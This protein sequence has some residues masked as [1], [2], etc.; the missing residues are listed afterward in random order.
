MNAEASKPEP[1]NLET[2]DEPTRDFRQRDTLTLFL[3][4]AFFAGFGLLV[5]LGQL[6]EQSTEGRWI[7]AGAGVTLLL[8]A[9][10][11]LALAVRMRRSS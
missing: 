8:V 4:G 5:L 10:A 3:L 11:C 2:R 1:S 7:N 9:A 6:W